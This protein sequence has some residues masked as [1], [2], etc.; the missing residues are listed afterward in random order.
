M[1]SSSINPSYSG[2][3]ACVF[4]QLGRLVLVCNAGQQGLDIEVGRQVSRLTHTKGTLRLVE[5]A[6][7]LVG[8]LLAAHLV[9]G[10]LPGALLA[11]WDDVT[12]RRSA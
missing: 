9:H 7:V 2:V 1:V 4:A 11:V 8:I 6:L 5:D 12:G 3:C 10:A